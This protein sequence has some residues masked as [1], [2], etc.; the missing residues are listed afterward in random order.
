MF[1]ACYLLRRAYG[2]FRKESYNKK[3]HIRQAQQ[4]V[5]QESRGIQRKEICF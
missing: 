4:R 1:L 3:M 2:L 5:S